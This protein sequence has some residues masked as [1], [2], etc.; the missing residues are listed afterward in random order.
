MELGKWPLSTTSEPVHAFS[1]NI[2][3][4][5]TVKPRCKIVG[6]LSLMGLLNVFT[7]KLII[8][9]GSVTNSENCIMPWTNTPHLCTS[10]YIK[11]SLSEHLGIMT[12]DKRREQNVTTIWFSMSLLYFCPGSQF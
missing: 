2:E 12:K 5:A 7:H 10:I 9:Q 1:I 11:F 3:P 6:L 8:L 4:S